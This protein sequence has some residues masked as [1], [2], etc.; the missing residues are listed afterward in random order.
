MDTPPI[1]IRIKALI[2]LCALPLLGLP[3]LISSPGSAEAGTFLALYPLF[4]VLCAA[5]AWKAYAGNPLLCYILLAV[6]L[7]THAAMWLLCYPAA[8]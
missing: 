7:L 6:M 4:V 3:W 1:P 2:V 5:C 8:L